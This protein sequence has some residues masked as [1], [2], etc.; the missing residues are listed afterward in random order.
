MNN[1]YKIFFI[2]IYSLIIGR[3][4]YIGCYCVFVSYV[5]GIIKVI[6]LGFF[7]FFFN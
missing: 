6:D 2:K 7:I 4:V 3:N 1:Y 5:V